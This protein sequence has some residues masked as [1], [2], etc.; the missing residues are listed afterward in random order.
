MEMLIVQLPRGRTAVVQFDEAAGRATTTH[1][2]LRRTLFENGVKDLDGNVLFPC[3]GRAFVAAVYDTLF[4]SG[5]AVR[6]L[7]SGGRTSDLAT[8]HLD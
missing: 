4:L 7:R 1:T 2:G 8:N 6:W 5:Y 3:D